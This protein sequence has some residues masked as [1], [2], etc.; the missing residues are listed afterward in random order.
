MDSHNQRTT[1]VGTERV[2]EI[3]ISTVRRQITFMN[4]F[5]GLEELRKHLTR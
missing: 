4:S 3:P 2:Q 1:K 5:T